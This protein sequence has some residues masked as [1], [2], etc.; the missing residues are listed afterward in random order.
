MNRLITKILLVWGRVVVALGG[1]CSVPLAIDFAS[2][3]SRIADRFRDS[4]FFVNPRITLET[5][6]RIT[7]RLVAARQ[8]RRSIAVSCTDAKSRERSRG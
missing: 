5:A 4:S 3:L 1:T 2:C 8:Q 7:L 6:V